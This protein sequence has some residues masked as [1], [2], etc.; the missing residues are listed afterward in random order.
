MKTL[1]VGTGN[2]MICKFFLITGG[3]GF[4]GSVIIRYTINNTDH[5]VVNIDKRMIYYP[6]SV[7][8]LA[9]INEIINPL[10]QL[11]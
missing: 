7:L 10:C 11:D 5:S 9:G 1:L 2:I 3:T 8:M 4:I 6:I